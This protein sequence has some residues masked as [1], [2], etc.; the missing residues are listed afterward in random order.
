MKCSSLPFM[1]KRK[2]LRGKIAKTIP[3][4][5]V[6]NFAKTLSVLDYVEVLL[7]STMGFMKSAT[8]DAGTMNEEKVKKL[9]EKLLLLLFHRNIKL[10]P[11]T[12]LTLISQTYKIIVIFKII[13]MIT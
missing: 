10:R 4:T 7:N 8:Q 12:N 9:N 3:Q 5:V 11:R 6:P 1:K 2:T 13:R